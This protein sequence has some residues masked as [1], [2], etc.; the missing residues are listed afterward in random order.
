[1]LALFGLQTVPTEM[2]YF[3][4][5][6]ATAAAVTFGWAT[7]LVTKDRGFGPVGNAAIGVAGA[8]M[9]PR[10]WFVGLARGSITAAD[11]TAILVSAGAAG[12]LLLLF[13]ML[14][15]GALARA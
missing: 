9:G 4:A 12:A 5:F 13:A 15:K 3:L 6:M 14:L 1:M 11:P 8:L 10:I 7:D 2:L